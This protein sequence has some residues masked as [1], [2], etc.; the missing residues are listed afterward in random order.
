MVKD[1]AVS[2]ALVADRAITS[3]LFGT[4]PYGRPSSG[5]PEELSKVDRAD[6]MLARERF[7]N[8]NN[9]TLAIVG[10][11][12]ENRA[13]RT[14][15]QLLGPWRRSEEVVPSTF[16]SPKA[17]DQRALIINA[18]SATSEVRLAVR[19]VARSDQQFY[20][21]LVLARIAQYR[22]QE[23][24][25]T[26]ASKPIS[27][28]SE[29]YT[30]PGYF[31]MSTSVNPPHVLNCILSAKKVLES[32]TSS[33]ASAAEIDRA[34]RE[35]LTEVSAKTS[36][37][38]ARPDAWLDA[39]TYRLGAIEDRS[40]L[41]QTVSAEDLQR[42]AARLFKDAAIATVI[43]GDSGQLKT[44]LDSKLPFEV[45]GE[46]AQPVTPTKTPTKPGTKTNPS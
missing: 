38:E 32:L 10:G 35:I 36:T 22:W 21:S 33:P 13:L 37:L 40:A 19:G 5:S 14:L 30:L 43:V 17:P 29:S 16:T 26:L 4:F 20:A 11:V 23:T 39:D 44:A 27:V 7:I 24:T 28:R 6:L 41:V 3:R 34:K 9:A 31:V 1:S 45:L 2:P 46:T 12:T 42:L 25:P 8:S 15:K 18:P